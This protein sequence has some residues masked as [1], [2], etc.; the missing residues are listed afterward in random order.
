MSRE[1]KPGDV[2]MVRL[3]KKNDASIDGESVHVAMRDRTESWASGTTFGRRIE[4]GDV[5]DARPLV[6]IDPE[7]REQVERL[8]RGYC[9]WKSDPDEIKNYPHYVDEMRAALREFANPK[10]PKPEEPTGLGAVVEDAEGDLWV[11]C[12]AEDHG[13]WRRAN[14]DALWRDYLSIDAVR[15]LSEGIDA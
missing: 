4:D 9:G 1:W 11:R 10:P 5:K 2:A 3:R 13:S 7:D 6:V 14:D 8:L 12:D 15:V